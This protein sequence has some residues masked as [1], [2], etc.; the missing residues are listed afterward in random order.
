[1]N[2]LSC[3]T[4]SAR[5]GSPSTRPGEYTRYAAH[6]AREIATLRRFLSSRNSRPRGAL[7]AEDAASETIAT[8]AS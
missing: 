8:T 3:A 5:C 6:L 7:A 4:P 1:M 2:A